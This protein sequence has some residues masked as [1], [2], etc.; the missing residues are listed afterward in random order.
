M[1]ETM[2]RRAGWAKVA[3]R[4]PAM[5]LYLGL[6]LLAACG[7]KE[8]RPEYYD[9]MEAPDLAIP[10][11]MSSPV[12]GSAL[13]I[14]A[15]PMPPPAYAMETMP[16]RI[17]STTSGLDANSRFNWSS[18]GLYLLVDDSSESAHRRLGLVIERAGM[19]RVRVDDKG[20]YRFDYYQTFD[21]DDGFFSSLAFWRRN[22]AEDYSGAYQTFVEPDGDKARV[23][24]KYA[25]GTDCEPDAAEHVLDV[26][27]TRLG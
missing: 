5:L 15:E 11:G 7:G 26:I 20:V 22:R 18:R 25:D 4:I 27:R 1:N 6:A 9:A 10:D 19:E 16:P 8:K 24:I 17:S 2:S 23:Y 14:A 21:S 13:L 3:S 12:T